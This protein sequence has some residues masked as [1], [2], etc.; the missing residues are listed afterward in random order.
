LVAASQRKKNLEAHLKF[1]SDLTTHP[2]TQI[3][4][5]FGAWA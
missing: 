2:V 1:S 4:D 3:V 5:R